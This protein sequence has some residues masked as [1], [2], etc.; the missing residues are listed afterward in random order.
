MKIR[1]VV[2]GILVLFSV[3]CSQVVYRVSSDT[4]LKMDTQQATDIIKSKLLTMEKS[5]TIQK[6]TF[7]GDFRMIHSNNQVI[8]VSSLSDVVPEVNKDGDA[9]SVAID[10]THVKRYLYWKSES[11][12]RQFVDAVYFLR[13]NQEG[14]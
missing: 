8:G 5:L 2:L 7:D 9:Y 13:K 14:R 4:P 10:T 6:I 1:L 12:A 11:D 3:G